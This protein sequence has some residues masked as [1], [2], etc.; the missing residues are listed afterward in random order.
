MKQQKQKQE[1]KRKLA[2][3]NYPVTCN[4]SWNLGEATGDGGNFL[5][6]IVSTGRVT[7]IEGGEG[8]V[9]GA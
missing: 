5:G 9:E 6:I 4:N 2:A 7:C 3:L 8:E 1:K